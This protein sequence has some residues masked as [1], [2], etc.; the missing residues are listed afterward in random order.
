MAV[1]IDSEGSLL[2]N[3]TGSLFLQPNTPAG[4]PTSP[5][6]VRRALENAGFNASSIKRMMG[7]KTHP[8]VNPELALVA[9]RAR[10]IYQAAHPDRSFEVEQGFRTQG[11]QARIAARGSA[12]TNCSGKKGHESPHQFGQAVDIHIYE[13]QPNGKFS[14][15]EDR[16]EN[17]R[18]Y[19]DAA[20]AMKQ[21]ARELGYSNKMNYGALGDVHVGH[22]KSRHNDWGHLE[23]KRQF[24]NQWHPPVEHPEHKAGHP[25]TETHAHH[26]HH[27]HRKHHH[28]HHTPTTPSKGK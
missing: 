4:N 12:F 25:A 9:A 20:N 15:Q 13:R 23:E 19:V 18:D 1:L 11:D 27:H 17:S 10:Q 5:D 24:W 8:G 14:R 3:Q 26:S 28:H 6:N 16:H 21:A 22:G 2:G 7:T